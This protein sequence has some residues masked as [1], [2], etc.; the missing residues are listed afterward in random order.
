VHSEHRATARPHYRPDTPRRAPA[1]SDSRG[2]SLERAVADQPLTRHHMQLHSMLSSPTQSRAARR[3]VGGLCLLT[4]FTLPYGSRVR[5]DATPE[6]QRV[7]DNVFVII[8]PDA[9]E[10]WPEGN[11]TVVV[12][13][14]GVLVVDAG[15]FPSTARHDI[16]LIRQL[17][18]KPVRILVNTHWHYDHN[19]GNSEYAR[20]YPGLEIVAHAD[21]RR[22]MQVTGPGYPRSVIDPESP[23]RIAL[24]RLRSN[25]RDGR[26]DAG[27]P[28][29][30]S[31]RAA[32]EQNVRQRE[33]EQRE[34]A[35]VRFTAP[36][37][38]FERELLV[39]LGGKDVEILHEGRGNTP[40]DAFVYLARERVLVS[41]DLLVAPV[42]FVYNSFPAHWVSVLDQLERLSPVVIVPGHGAVMHDVRY[43]TQVRVLLSS[44]VSQAEALA[45]RRVPEEQA[46]KQIDLE[47]FRAAFTHGDKSANA[48]FDEVVRVLPGRAYREAR[49]II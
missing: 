23:S 31:E 1:Y 49:G 12:G 34:L 40:G 28:L 48:A 13:D 10:E 16:A 45:R 3:F 47:P 4:P 17:T 30:E 9:T 15:Y 38:T 46:V 25:L 19:N 26:T 43:L 36:T 44:A 7:A 29:S 39:H 35:A 11:T 42:P 41:G 33:T 18:A 27:A 24:E 32:I 2:G 37:L 5:P 22:I 6:L 14:S 20:A 21:T 8:H